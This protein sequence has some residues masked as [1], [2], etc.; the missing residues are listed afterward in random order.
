MFT[1]L[2][3]IGGLAHMWSSVDSMLRK[4][5]NLNAAGSAIIK[6]G[7]VLSS[8]EDKTIAFLK[9]FSK[10][11]STPHTVTYYPINAKIASNQPNATGTSFSLSEVRSSPY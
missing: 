9:S 11:L 4:V 7:S 8:L 10:D 1:T 6:D 2:D 3:P 5:S